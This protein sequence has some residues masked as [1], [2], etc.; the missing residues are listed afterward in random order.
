MYVAWIMDARQ[1]AT[2]ERRLAQVMNALRRGKP[3]GMK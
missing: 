1:P 3:L 2:R